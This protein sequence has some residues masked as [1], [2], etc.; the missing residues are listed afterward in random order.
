MQ[1]SLIDEVPEFT[2]SYFVD[3]FAEALYDTK[4]EK[5]KLKTING[6]QVPEDLK[7]AI[8]SKFIANYPE[9]TIYKVDTKLVNI[10]GKRPYFIA[11]RAKYVQRAIE[12]FD[13]N[14]KV[15]YGFDYC[16]RK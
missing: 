3:V 11:K 5:M 9:G 2:K 10:K 13:Y 12:F 16:R 4:A 14:L 7:V 8:S 1:L 6:Q 15:Q